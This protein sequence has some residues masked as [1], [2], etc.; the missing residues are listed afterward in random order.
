MLG[1]YVHLKSMSGS[2]GSIRMTV[3]SILTCFMMTVAAQ[4]L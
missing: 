3:E 2:K 1:V 4:S